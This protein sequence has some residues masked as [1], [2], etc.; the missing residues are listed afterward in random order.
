[1]CAPRPQV[2]NEQFGITSQGWKAWWALH[3]LLNVPKHY[4][5]GHTDCNRFLYFSTCEA[6]AAGP[7]SRRAECCG[8]HPSWA[9]Y[10]ENALELPGICECAT[11]L[12]DLYTISPIMRGRVYNTVLFVRDCQNESWNHKLGV[13][14]P[15]YSHVTKQQQITNACCC[16]LDW[17]EDKVGAPT[18]TRALLC[19]RGARLQAR[20]R[21]RSRLHARARRITK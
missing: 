19:P 5:G 11:L 6:Q 13:W 2:V 7:A 12:L 1:M 15:Q 17:N 18:P 8:K 20:A 10:A 9:E 3:G 21:A 4:C 14:S 16:S